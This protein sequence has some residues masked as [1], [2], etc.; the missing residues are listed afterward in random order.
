VCPEAEDNYMRSSGHAL[1]AHTRRAA[2]TR[3]GVLA[4]VAAVAASGL[5]AGLGLPSASAAAGGRHLAAVVT[6]TVERVHLDDFAHPLPADSDELTFVRTADGALQVPAAQL[7]KVPNGATVRLGLADTRGARVG[8]SGSL[9]A[10]LAGADARDPEAGPTVASVEVVDS[11]QA[12]EVTTGT[13]IA[14]TDTAVAAGTALHSVLVVVARPPGGVTTSVTAADVAATINNGVNSYWSTVTA[15]AVGFTASAYPTVVATASAPCSGGGVG[16]SSSFWSEIQSKTGW[17]S[18]SGRHLLVYFPAY[19]ECG[20]IAG[21]GT[22]GG[23][24]ASGGVVWTNGYGVGSQ[25]VGVMGHELGHNLGLGHSQLLDCTA[26][27]VRVMDTDPGSCT[28]RSYADTNDIMA[29]SWN[30][31]GFLNSVHLRTLGLLGADEVAPTDN[32]QVTLAPIENAA[33][34]RVLTLSDGNTRYVVEFRLPVGRDSWMSSYP[35]WGSVGVT[36]RKEFD[37]T[38]P[39]TGSFSRI[40]S[41]LL[42]GDPGTADS[43]FGAMSNTLPVGSWIDLAGG[44]LGVRV[45]SLSQ[46]GA[47]VDYRNGDATVDPRY[48]APVLPEV[49]V[50]SARLTVGAM[51][52]SSYG[53][54]VPILWRWQVTMP[55]TDPAAAATVTSGSHV[56]SAVRMG[57]TSWLDAAY[58]AVALASNGTAVTSTGRARTHYTSEVNSRV[59]HFSSG[60]TRTATSKANNGSLRTTSKKGAGVSFRVTSRSLGVLLAKGPNA[61]TVAIYIDHRRVGY[62]KLRANRNSVVLAWTA[63]FGDLSSHL[64]TIQNVTG[65]T[66]GK[67]GFDGVATIV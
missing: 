59:V 46:T 23:G 38:Q 45:A 30:Y 66:R 42:D 54:S 4:A 65:G 20:G 8:A 58:R 37:T 24:V 49:S 62:V 28:A 39:G 33:G 27:G 61:G 9:V 1:R 36:V 17:T 67:L 16:G 29:V 48:V 32:G 25:G 52:P 19:A 21:L 56:S 34:L 41:Y 11:V 12:G 60:W 40:E 35:A 47:V 7:D 50:P 57:A 53:P 22:V 63:R 5:V 3:P 31:Q 13:G 55:S 10:D 44:R 26:S 18:G 43:G 15:G 64:V 2:F 14:T 51:K 6:G